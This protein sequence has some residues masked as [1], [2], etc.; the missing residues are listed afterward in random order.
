MSEIQISGYQK[1]INDLK[2]KNQKELNKWVQNYLF[3][4]QPKG[5][6]PS[7]V[8]EIMHKRADDELK[9]RLEHSIEDLII[10][11][12]PESDP[13]EY[14]QELLI[15]VSKLKVMSAY[16]K[17]LKFAKVIDG[18]LKSKVTNVIDLHLETLR[19]LF[20]LRISNDLKVIIKRDIREQRYAV[21]A[22]KKIYEMENGFSN[23]I[24]YLKYL[25]DSY[26]EMPPSRQQHVF[27]GFCMSF[28]CYEFVNHLPK[29]LKVISERR[30][31]KF[32]QILEKI[33]V[34]FH[35]CYNKSLP[36]FPTKD[37]TEK[38]MIT[39]RVDPS[40]DFILTPI[41]LKL[42]VPIQKFINE[43]NR[44]ERINYCISDENKIN[45]YQAKL[46]KLAKDYNTK[47]QN[48]L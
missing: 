35:L 25:L 30:H 4:G 9:D 41:I 33:R 12:K 2:Q 17:L 5:T 10:R 1:V 44:I 22:F 18:C 23:G 42:S 27:A 24:K 19:A 45:E 31:I 28:Q 26:E 7:K 47:Y 6:Y 29:I 34:S 48:E 3:F 16:S 46:L 13:V 8:I 43:K 20:S 40:K 38:I 37:I 39:W 32:M 21:Y 15:V 14:S 11:W 36:T